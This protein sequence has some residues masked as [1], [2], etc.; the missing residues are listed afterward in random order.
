MKSDFIFIPSEL[1]L[2]VSRYDEAKVDN[3][4]WKLANTFSAIEPILHT[5]TVNC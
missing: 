5:F 2:N 4:R 3:K 1:M